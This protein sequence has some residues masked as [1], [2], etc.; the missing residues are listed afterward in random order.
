MP[1]DMSSEEISERL[2][3][4][5]T[6]DPETLK[7]HGDCVLTGYVHDENAI[8]GFRIAFNAGETDLNK[9]MEAAFRSWL[10]ACQA[11]YA[12]QQSEEQFGETCEANEYEFTEDGVLFNVSR[13]GQSAQFPN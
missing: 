11:D 12:D 10:A 1:D 13:A 5:G 9:L 3:S 6:Y 2:A 7:G 4:L 8:D